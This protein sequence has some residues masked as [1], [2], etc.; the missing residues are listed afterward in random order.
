MR[1]LN[2]TLL[3]RYLQKDKVKVPEGIILMYEMAERALDPA[4]AEKLKEYISQ[5]WPKIFLGGFCRGTLI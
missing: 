4:V 3:Y 2:F 5:V 1:D